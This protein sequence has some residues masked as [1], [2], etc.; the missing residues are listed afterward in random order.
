[1]L[2]ALQFTFERIVQLMFYILKNYQT[3]GDW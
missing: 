1:M 3:D 2:T